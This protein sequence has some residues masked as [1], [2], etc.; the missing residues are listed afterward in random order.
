MGITCQG[1]APMAWGRASRGLNPR[2]VRNTTTLDR[3]GP[4]ACGVRRTWLIRSRSMGASP[5]ARRGLSRFGEDGTGRCLGQGFSGRGTRSIEP[6]RPSVTL[7][8]PVLPAEGMRMELPKA[9][10]FAAAF[11]V[12]RGDG[13]Q[14]APLPH[15]RPTRPRARPLSRLASHPGLPPLPLARLPQALR[16]LAQA[17]QLFA[18]ARIDGGGTIASSPQREARA[19]PR[20]PSLPSAETLDGS[21]DAPLLSRGSSSR[22]L[23]VTQP[24]VLPRHIAW[25]EAEGEGESGG[26]P[27]Q[28][29][30]RVP[31]LARGA[32][33]ARCGRGLPAAPSRKMRVG[34][35]SLAIDGPVRR[36]WIA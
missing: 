17:A 24:H 31:Y 35:M 19:R 26:T 12:F 6:P 14:F 22:P 3:T 4:R 9:Q 33:R 7:P 23:G 10:A 21:L 8:A 27:G 16:Q 25:T 28:D 32:R 20:R 30:R 36:S 5:A 13:A 1:G 34:N 18:D 11:T 2:G 29:E 15:R